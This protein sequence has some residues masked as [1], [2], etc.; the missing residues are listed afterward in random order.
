M[1]SACVLCS[2]GCGLDIGV[3][4][5]RIV[6]VRGRAVDRVNRGR[7][8]PKGL[9][10]WEANHSP[11]RLTRPLI[12][13]GGRLREASWDEAMG[14]IV[15]EVEGDPRRA[16]P[17]APSASTP[18]GQL[19]LEEYYTLG[20]I[21]KAGLGTPHMDGNTR[22]CTAT[23]AA[24]PEGDL[25]RRR[26]AG[27]LRR[28]RRHRLHP[29]W[30][31]TTSPRSRPCSGCAILDRRARPEPAE[32]GRHRPAHA[33]RRPTEADVHLAPRV[34]T[35]VA[36]LNGLLH[37]L[38]EAGQIDREFIDA[39][40]RRLRRAA[41]R[42]SRDYPPERV[43]EITGVPAATA[44]AGGARSSATAPTLVSTVPPGRLPV[45]PGDAPR[46]CQ[47]NN[48]NL[49]R[50][51]IGKPG[52]GVLQMNGQPTAQNTREMR[53]RRRA[54]RLPQLGQP[55]A[56]RTSWPGSGTS[57]R[58]TIPHWAP[59]THAMQIFRYAETGSI[60]LALDQRHQP[61]RLAAR[62][63]RAS[64]R[65]CAT[66]ELFVVVQD[67]F[68]TE[69]ARARRRRAAGGDLGREDRHASPTPTAPST[70]RTRR[71]SRPARRGPTS[72]S[73]STSPG[74]WTS[75]TRTAQPLIKWRDAGGRLRGLE[76]VHPRAGP[77][78]T[79]GL[80]YAKLTGGSGI[81]WPCNEQHPD[82]S[83]AALHRRRLP[84]RRR[85]YCET[86]G[87]DLVTGGAI[88]AGRVPGARPRRA[89]RSSR[90]PTTSRRTRSPTTTTRSG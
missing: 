2:N 10:G 3:K 9:H 60:K 61:G 72:T 52:C 57:S 34:G 69:T 75:A 56:H 90:P 66:P 54:A 23:A 27:L 89:G 46:P 47:V 8:G 79:R 42:P 36:V 64:A 82:G 80:S 1:Q 71:S 49:I 83:R 17:A 76:G 81:Q 28:H 26:P 45:E 18:A 73:S 7:L 24:A 6:G 67:A 84:D 20:V 62:A 48:L 41:R 13:E 31:A 86:Y 63:A 85:T 74:G 50:G 11:D 43:E 77:A 33:P 38:I 32:A 16:T 14:L 4:D 29:A 65:S 22:L 87:H 44:A 58:D 19:F 21:G 40:H 30:S 59:P 39:A 37:L 78:T 12:R 15:R 51:M 68:L 5:G 35:N 55:R 70:S 25:R 88:D 53:R